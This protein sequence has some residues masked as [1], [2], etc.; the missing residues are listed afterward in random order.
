MD[1]QKLHDYA[2]NLIS[3]LQK[4][5]SKKTYIIGHSFGGRIAI[6]IAQTT[7][8]IID[9]IIL[10]AASGLKKKRTMLFRSK[11]FTMQTIGK[12]L[13]MIDT[14]LHTSTK[15][16]YSRNFGSSDYRA[17]RGIMRGIFIKTIQK[18]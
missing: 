17:T 11:A 7:T 6:H 1:N 12:C 10:I 5:S 14:C 13:S 18:R 8:P 4:L 2:N 15:E 3:W 16:R 9:G